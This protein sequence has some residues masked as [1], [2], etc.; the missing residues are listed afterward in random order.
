MCE[1][2]RPSNII[3]ALGKSSCLAFNFLSRSKKLYFVVSHI[4]I[5]YYICM[6]NG[7]YLLPFAWQQ[8]PIIPLLPPHTAI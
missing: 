6:L 3:R 8:F 4:Y 7:R 1:T 5:Y 2:R